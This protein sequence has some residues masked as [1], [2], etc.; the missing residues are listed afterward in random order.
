MSSPKFHLKHLAFFFFLFSL[1]FQDIFFPPKAS[2]LFHE[3]NICFLTQAMMTSV[4]RSQ[5]LPEQLL[6]ALQRVQDYFC[7]FQSFE[8]VQIQNIY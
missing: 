5:L 3:H 4:E 6:L 7:S 2:K 1:P 8:A